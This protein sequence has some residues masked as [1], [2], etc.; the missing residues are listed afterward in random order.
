[1]TLKNAIH[2][3]FWGIITAG[4]SL[5]FQLFIISIAIS[6]KQSN[7]INEVFLSSLL[8]LIVYAFSEEAFKYF[9]VTK[10]I[11]SLSYGRGFL[12]NSWI[13]GVGFS[14]LEIFIIYEKNIYEKIDFQIID[15]L[16]TAPLHILTFGTLGYFLSI[17]DK[18]GLNIKILFFNFILHFLYNYSIIYL[19]YY[20]YF[21]TSGLIILLLLVNIY[22]FL[23]V[24]K[25]LASD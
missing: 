2:S 1:M 18:K 14:L 20:S 21:I 15:L 4:M 16:K 17:W 10:K 9:I 6:S 8:F 7:E 12:V 3:L 23:I 24:N 19:D 25:K 11:I 22:G 13:A 5:A